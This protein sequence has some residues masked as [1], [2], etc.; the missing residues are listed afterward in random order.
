MLIVV[1]RVFIARSLVDMLPD[2]SPCEAVEYVIPLMNG[3]AMDE[4]WF[5]LLLG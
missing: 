1:K 4:G 5:C 3:L 2:V